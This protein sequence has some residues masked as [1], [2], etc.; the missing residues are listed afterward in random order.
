M[1]EPKFFDIFSKKNENLI[2]IKPKITADYREKNSLVIPELIGLGLDVEIKELK[3]GDFLV[4]ETA[5]ERKTINDFLTSMKNKRLLKQIED[6]KQYPNR[7]I[8]IEGIYE[9]ELYNDHEE[10]I[11]GN[12]T[13]GLVLSILLKHKIPII[14]SKDYSDTAKFISVL[15]K[16]KEK[17]TSFYV[18]KNA[19]DKKEQM[20]FILE[21]FRGIGPSTAKKLLEKF[22]TLENIFNQPIEKI[23]E[24]IGKK[25][26]SL[27]IIK[28]E[29]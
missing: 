9:K 29:Y 25:A 21:G 18:K 26:E 7:L 14:F 13:R 23:K 6:L 3:V 28:E 16:K 19:S 12:A 1:N 10:G 22:K 27:K 5:I 11:N 8:I 24:I 20:Q 15:A 2:K 17:E 4:G